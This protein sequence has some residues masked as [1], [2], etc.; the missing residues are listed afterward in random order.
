MSECTIIKENGQKCASPALKGDEYCFTH[1]NKP[2]IVEKRELAHREGGHRS[3]LPRIDSEEWIELKSINDV[4]LFL[5]RTANEVRT[6]K[7]DRG[8]AN[9]LGYLT[10]ILLGALET[11]DLNARVEMLERVVIARK[12]GLK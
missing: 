4:V 6:G 11:R 8:R 2:G 10:N 7:I 9:T 3:K 1:S 5:E 12:E